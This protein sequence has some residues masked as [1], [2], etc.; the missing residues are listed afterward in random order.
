MLEIIVIIFGIVT[1]IRRKYPMGKGKELVGGRARIIGGILLAYLP[2]SLAAG[3]IYDLLSGGDAP[4][5]TAMGISIALLI[6]T[7]VVAI[8]LSKSLYKKQ[9]AEAATPPPTPQP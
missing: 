7:I 9:E 1:L 6:V 4:R 3:L 8:I 2:L 5:G